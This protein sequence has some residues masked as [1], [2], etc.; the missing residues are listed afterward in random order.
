LAASIV[1]GKA[2][3]GL[4]IRA[5]ARR[6][7]LGFVPLQRERF[8]LAFRRRDYFEPPLQALF[9]FARTTAFAERARELEGYDIGG[10]GRVIYNA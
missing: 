10:T 6:F 2:D 9:A 3:C 7:R 5:S 4:S 1:D 8:D